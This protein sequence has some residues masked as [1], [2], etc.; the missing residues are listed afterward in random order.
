[1]R[2]YN[3]PDLGEHIKKHHYFEKKLVEFEI[4]LKENPLIIAFDIL[5]F[6]KNWLVTH[7]LY[8]DTKIK[9]YL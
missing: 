6:L 1:M 8:E 5:D 7:I 2:K 4:E 3:Y 9:N